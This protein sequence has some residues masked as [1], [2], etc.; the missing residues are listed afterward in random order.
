[1][2][3]QH[4][5]LGNFIV[6]KRKNSQKEQKIVFRDIKFT[7][8][9]LHNGHRI[10]MYCF[11]YDDCKI[12]NQPN[13]IDGVGVLECE[14]TGVVTKIRGEEKDSFK[15]KTSTVISEPVGWKE[16]E[17][18]YEFVKREMPEY[19]LIVSGCSFEIVGIH[20]Y[21]DLHPEV[22]QIVRSQNH[23]IVCIDYPSKV[24]PSKKAR[25]EYIEINY[26]P[27]RKRTKFFKH[28]VYDKENKELKEDHYDDFIQYPTITTYPDIVIS[29]YVNEEEESCALFSLKYSKEITQKFWK[30][31]ELP[32]HEFLVIDRL[33]NGEQMDY[34]SFRINEDGKRVSKVYS[35]N[36]AGFLPIEEDAS[37]D[38]I[39]NYV[40]SLLKKSEE[41]RKVYQ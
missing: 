23:F 37:I 29:T 19:N 16:I 18:Q 38:D 1:M 17:E 35:R 13:F 8:I 9:S 24:H 32:T 15:Y 36:Q 2:I 11:T 25:K 21:F 20:P 5:Q 30:I 7:N 3:I 4:N 28:F 31:K 41:K 10:D 34:I 40:E 14:L 22:Y 27:I 12:L 6:E 33:V 26:K 39:Y